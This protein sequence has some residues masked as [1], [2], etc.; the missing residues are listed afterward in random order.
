YGD[1]DVQTVLTVDSGEAAPAVVEAPTV[2]GTAK[3]GRTLTATPGTWNPADVTTAYQ[4][5]RDGEPVNGVTSATYRV[6]RADLGRV[7]SV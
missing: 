7:L 4:W 5:L 6:Q 1:S 3:L 2:S